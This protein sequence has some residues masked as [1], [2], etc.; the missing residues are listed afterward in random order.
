MDIQPDLQAVLENEFKL[1]DHLVNHI[2]DLEKG[3]RILKK[4]YELLNVRGGAGGRTD[5]LA[6]DELDH[7]VVIEVK[8]SDKT[9]R[10]TIHELSKYI[11]LLIERDRVPRELIRCVVVS[12]VWHEL[13]L[14]LAYF[15][16][17]AQVDVIG[18]EPYTK[19][20]SLKF[21][22]RDLLPVYT[23]PQ[24]SPEFC[25]YHYADKER[26]VTHIARIGERIKNVPFAR[27]ASCLFQGSNEN[28]ESG[29]RAIVC[30]WRIQPRDYDVLESAMGEP[31][32]H[33][34][35]YAYPGW[36]AE[37]D[38]LSWLAD[39][40]AMGCTVFH[41]AESERGTPEKV[42]SISN[43]HRFVQIDRLGDWP[44]LEIVNTFERILSQLTA[45]AGLTGTPRRNRH[46]FDASASPQFLPSWRKTR[47]EFIDFLRG[48][49]QW[50][51][52]V[53]EV[54]SQLEPLP[55]LKV[56]F[57]AFDKNHFF[58][59]LHQCTEHEDVGLSSFA[60]VA[61]QGDNV[62]FVGQGSWEWN[63]SRDFGPARQEIERAFGSTAGAVLAAYSAVDMN[64]YENAYVAHGFHPYIR[65]L[66]RGKSGEQSWIDVLRS[67]SANLPLATF[68]ERHR[69]YVNE[70]SQEL[71]LVGD[72]PTSPPARH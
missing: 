36:E 24:F 63:G 10:E 52:F 61:R 69:D 11:S 51:S 6:A 7:I 67:P 35:P 41:S 71:R 18:M 46:H 50:Q 32:G 22:R 26:Y 43:T 48:V 59:A 21:R 55:D 42:F 60:I 5:I 3:L 30:Q 28:G 39:E 70:V 34:F 37:C 13:E 9:A 68:V 57:L 49:P 33:L 17:T 15:R 27:V 8:R 23:L 65:V 64:R 20:N 47:G 54:C 14:P 19:G 66:A 16:A 44:Q 38:C 4:E 25:I 45:V 72:L 58:Y 1:R 12:T 31:I 40:T 2:E 62:V 29:L 56:T 53:A